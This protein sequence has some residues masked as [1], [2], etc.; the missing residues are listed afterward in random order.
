MN[1]NPNNWKPWQQNIIGLWLLLS[2]LFVLLATIEVLGWIVILFLPPFFIL[3]Y[4]MNKEIRKWRE[5]VERLEEESRKDKAFHYV[6]NAM[7]GADKLRNEYIEWEKSELRKEA[8]HKKNIESAEDFLREFLSDGPRT[9]DEIFNGARLVGISVKSLRL[10]RKAL[11]VKS[12]QSRFGESRR[13]EWTLPDEINEDYRAT[14]KRLPWHYGLDTFIELKW[15]ELGGYKEF[16][17]TEESHL[18]DPPKER[19]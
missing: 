17:H 6:V 1:L 15:F 11:Q 13:W 19:Q 9:A 3:F 4:S 10:A 16:G 12:S 2:I 18:V 5:K 7:G 14:V 8:V